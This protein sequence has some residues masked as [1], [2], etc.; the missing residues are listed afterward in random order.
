MHYLLLLANDPEGWEDGHAGD[1][2]G[3]IETWEAYT[4]ALSA[5]GVLVSGAS[6]HP[7]PSATSVRVRDGRRVLTDGPFAETKEHLVGFYLIDVDDLDAALEWAARVPNVRTGTVEVRPLAD[8]SLVA[9][10]LARGS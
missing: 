3:V 8:Q 2:D 4:D 6:L 5:A 10:A 9:A 1:D 7:A